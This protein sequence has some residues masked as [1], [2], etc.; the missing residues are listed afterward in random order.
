L[1][2]ADCIRELSEAL[3]FAGLDPQGYDSALT[4]I[5][6]VAQGMLATTAASTA[7]ARLMDADYLI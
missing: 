4:A 1:L 2:V 3:S 6:A 7:K 5:G